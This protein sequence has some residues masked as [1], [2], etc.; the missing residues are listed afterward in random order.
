MEP[1]KCPQY[2]PRGHF[3]NNI[4]S[5]SSKVARILLKHS[6]GPNFTNV[7]SRNQEL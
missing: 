7:E 1:I 5:T 2:Y 3:F 6:Y 4:E